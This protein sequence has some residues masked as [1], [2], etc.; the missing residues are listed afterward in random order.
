MKPNISRLTPLTL[1]LVRMVAPYFAS[2]GPV[3]GLNCDF[4]PQRPQNPAKVK[5]VSVFG[6]EYSTAMDCKLVFSSSFIL[7]CNACLTCMSY[8]FKSSIGL[9]E[10]FLRP[11][12]R[13]QSHV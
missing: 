4:Q 1:Y 5:A 10:S 8:F 9:L 2:R 3:T 12:S 6:G 11:P 7:V 13:L